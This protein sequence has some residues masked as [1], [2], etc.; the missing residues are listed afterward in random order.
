MLI[1]LGTRYNLLIIRVIGPTT[2]NYHSDPI[3][4]SALLVCSFNVVK[5]VYM[6]GTGSSLSLQG[7]NSRPSISHM[8]R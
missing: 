5:G 4:A 1:V 3:T 7:C 2:G 6:E 8:H